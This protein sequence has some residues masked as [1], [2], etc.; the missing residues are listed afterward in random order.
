VRAGAIT[1]QRDDEAAFRE[2]AGLPAPSAPVERTWASEPVRRPITL[3][4]A[5]GQRPA[6]SAGNTDTEE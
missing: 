2:E 3:A 5:D 1:P 4:N 6:G